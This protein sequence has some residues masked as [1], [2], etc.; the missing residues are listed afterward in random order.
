MSASTKN[1]R[2]AFFRTTTFGTMALIENGKITKTLR[3]PNYRAIT[4]P[5]WNSLAM[6]GNESTFEVHGTPNCGKGEPNQAIR[7][8]HAS[9]VCLFENVEVFGGV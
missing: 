3:D 6:V 2:Q 5:F 8:G 7:V 1:A 9:P 4:V